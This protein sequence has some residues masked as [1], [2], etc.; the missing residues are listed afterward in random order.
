MIGDDDIYNPFKNRTNIVLCGFEEMLEKIAKLKD[1]YPPYNL[2]RN[3][4]F[5]IIELAVAGF[6]KEDI[7]IRFSGTQLIIIGKQ[8]HQ[9]NR[10]YIY[11]G[12]A[13][14]PFEKSFYF[15]NNVEIR[16]ISLNN[17]LLSVLIT[18][19][20]KDEEFKTILLP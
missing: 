6:T 4:N 10:D 11:K 12:I 20:I 18:R 3:D 2:V 7:Q 5:W 1:N 14:R 13:M 9:E 16:D 8:I 15:L 19:Q 17:G